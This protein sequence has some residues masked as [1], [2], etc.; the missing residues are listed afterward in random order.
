MPTPENTDQSLSMMKTV[1]YDYRASRRAFGLPEN[2]RMLH[3]TIDFWF[4]QVSYSV[5]VVCLTKSAIG[6]SILHQPTAIIPKFVCLVEH[7]RNIWGD[8]ITFAESIT[9]ST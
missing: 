5:I 1:H 4:W 3:L 8:R 2:D 9:L 6:N 7:S